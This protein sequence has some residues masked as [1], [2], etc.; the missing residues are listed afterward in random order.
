MVSLMVALNTTKPTKYSEG[1]VN[2]IL[3]Y[4]YPSICCRKEYL[5]AAAFGFG[6]MC[7]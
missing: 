6:G 5:I 3:S 7:L 1:L 2:A 4:K